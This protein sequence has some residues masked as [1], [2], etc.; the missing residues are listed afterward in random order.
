MTTYYDYMLKF[1]SEQECNEMLF[2]EMDG[3][4]GPYKVPNYTAVDVIGII[5]EPTGNMIDTDE[6]PV[7]EMAPVDGWHANVRNIEEAPEL[8]PYL[9]YP[10]SPVRVWA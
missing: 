1:A 3:P 2:T 10:Q 9:V 6:G 4:E 8:D 7:P 5:Y